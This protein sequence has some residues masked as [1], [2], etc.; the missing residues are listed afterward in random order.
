MLPLL[1]LKYKDFDLSFRLHQAEKVAENL[2]VQGAESLPEPTPE[3]ADK[4]RE[5]V[6]L[7]PR[8]AILERSRDL[9]H[10]VEAFAA[11]VGMPQIRTRGLL[12][13]TREL[14]KNELIDHATSSLLD[15]L[16]AI[17]N[18]AAHGRDIDITREDA[19]RFAALADR[20][21]RQFQISAA[22]AAALG[23]P[24]GYPPQVP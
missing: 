9:E 7:S 10:A 20:A 15:D 2:R 13:W 21:I 14:R 16:R 24:V 19:L 1:R 5:L 22:A 17:R 23:Q 11:S 4:F 18:S 8:A 3:E 12:D 6:E